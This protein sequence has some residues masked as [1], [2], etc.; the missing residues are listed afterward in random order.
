MANILL[1]DDSDVA[2]R[3]MRGILG[4]AGHRCIV[5][6]THEEAWRLLREGV[7]IDLVFVELRTAD[8]SG[9][10]FLQ[11]VRDDPFWK[12][13]PLVVYTIDTDAKQVRKALGLRV[14]NYLVKPYND[15]VI[16]AEIG[17][18]M[19]NPWRNLHFEEPR[20]FCAQMNLTL[21][22]LA[23][24]RRQVMM[25]FDDAVNTF[26]LWAQSRENNE[27]FARLDA[28][29][30]DA[31]A[32]GIWAGV[33]F[34]RELRTQAELG[35]WSVF[36]TTAE[37]LDYASRLIFCQ[38]NPS[39]VPEVLKPAEELDEVKQAAEKARWL[40][41]DVDVSGP[42]IGEAQIQKEVKALAGCPAI[43]TAAAAFV[44]AADGRASSM[45]R[46][47][48]LAHEDPGLC[49]QILIAANR[50]EHD[51][52][53]SIED[54][55]TAVT[56]LGEIKLNSIAKSTLTIDEKYL[57][58]GSLN[59]ASYWMF[60]IGVAKLAQFISEYLEFRYLSSTAYTAGILHDIGK[61][62]VLRLHPWSFSAIA[63]YAR[64]K[65]IM[66]HE[67]EK[68]Y[69][70]CTS[71]ELAVQFAEQ[72]RLPA[73][74]CNVIRHVDSPEHATEGVELVAMVALARHVCLHN[75]VG[76]CG[77]T[78]GDASP[79]I[80]STQAWQVLHPRLFPSFDLRKFEA[81]A[82]AYCRELRMTLIGQQ[83]SY[84]PRNG[85]RPADNGR[86]LARSR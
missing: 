53:T 61:L 51:D 35:N 41:A 23:K 52:L 45:S 85:S 34:L 78:P 40:H 60:L 47:M 25:A 39:Y 6:T 26:P 10:G 44:M 2:G 14:Q 71:R 75:R 5:A 57:Q 70:G 17:K 54:P 43:D 12:S 81:H 74:Y 63:T 27:V 28:L 20:S 32:A 66:L 73:V 68:R 49:A 82:H 4:K 48:E 24:M 37:Y 46:V 7:V 55:N 30:N 69:F 31:E 76:H 1:L 80:S 15:Q 50:I 16:Y 21:D 67:A 62:L 58:V 9:M 42:V 38:L 77:D 3:A 11:R 64:E 8:E 22:G 84:V 56:M 29:A 86:E 18:A 83:P 59:W 36:K 72:Q 19:A 33:D 13:L 65:K 79:P